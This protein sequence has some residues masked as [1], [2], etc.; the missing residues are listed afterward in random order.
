M[1]M[2]YELRVF[3]DFVA[4]ARQ[5]A[6]AGTEL[7]RVMIARSREQLEH[8]RDLLKIKAPSVRH[9]RPEECRRAVSP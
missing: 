8:S 5:Q 6:D 7:T 3:A 9:Q 1:L 4:H 2:P